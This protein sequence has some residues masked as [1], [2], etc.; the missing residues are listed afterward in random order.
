MQS[1]GNDIVALDK[2]DHRRSSEYRFYSKIISPE[3]IKLYHQPGMDDLR[4]AETGFSV[5]VWICWSVKEAA[6]KFLKRNISELSFAPIRFIIESMER[7][8]DAEGFHFYTSS[9]I[10]KTVYGGNLS[11]HG[12]RILFK[13][14]VTDH[15]ITACAFRNGD[16][17]FSAVHEILSEEREHQSQ[18]VRNYCLMELQSALSVND[19]RIDKH[20]DGYPLLMDGIKEVALPL[21][22]AHHG[23]FVGYSVSR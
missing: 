1:T 4:P 5:F 18:A 23:R 6:Y 15:M 19:L 14:I 7:V 12:H 21:S 11:V 17:F 13:A 22:F 3:E 10:T 20:A 8:D 9:A 2:V 16:R